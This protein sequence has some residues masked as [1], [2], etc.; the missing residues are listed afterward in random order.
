MVPSCALVITHSATVNGS[1]SPRSKSAP[2]PRLMKSFL[3]SSRTAL[4]RTPGTHQPPKPC[5]PLRW[6]GDGKLRF[7]CFGHDWPSGKPCCS[8]ARS[9][10]HVLVQPREKLLVP[11]PRVLRPQDPVV[12][13]REIHQPRRHA[14][15]LQRR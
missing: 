9:V 14:L 13:V 12:L 2:S 8:I 6:L 4:P 10:P 15:E 1:P 5:L 3:P 7:W 11:Q